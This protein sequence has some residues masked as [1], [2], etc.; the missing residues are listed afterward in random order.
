M[1]ALSIVAFVAACSGGDGTNVVTDGPDDDETTDVGVDA[2]PDEVDTSVVPEAIAGNL[3]S[4]SYSDNG[5]PNNNSDDTLLVDLSALDQSPVNPDDNLE[6]EYVRNTAL[7]VPGYVAF[8]VQDDPLDRLFVAMVGE[9]EDG[10]VRAA[11]VGD[12]GQFGR[13]FNGATYERDEGAEIPTTGLVSYAGIYT[14]LTNEDDLDQDQILAPEAGTPS[15]LLPAQ[16]RQTIGGIFLNVDFDDLAANGVIIERQF[17]DGEGLDD[18]YLTDGVLD[19][20]GYFTGAAGMVDDGTLVTLGSFG[21]VIGNNG[22]ALAGALALDTIYVSSDT[23]DGDF[24]EETG[25]FVLPRCGTDTS[26]AI[27][28]QVDDFD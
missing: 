9:S 28:D 14:G 24:D 8:S 23:R 27:C 3:S 6:A 19:E 15:Q 21:G 16:P 2:D 17:T 5:T 26:P 11:V 20:D 18:V 4:I 22:D 13:Y 7:D 1:S 10:S 12:G 25:I